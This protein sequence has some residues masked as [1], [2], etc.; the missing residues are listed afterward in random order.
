MQLDDHASSSGVVE[1]EN[2]AQGPEF[3]Q[4]IDVK[5]SPWTEFYSAG[6][7][8][9]FPKEFSYMVF[10]GIDKKSRILLV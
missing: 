4:L 7:Q 10:I 1:D 8:F 3:G 5:M 6:L 2:S 9:G